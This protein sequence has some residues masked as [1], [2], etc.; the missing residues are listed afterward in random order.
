M[1]CALSTTIEA[2]TISGSHPP[3]GLLRLVKRT[4]EKRVPNTSRTYLTPGMW[5][6]KDILDKVLGKSKFVIQIRG[7]FNTYAKTFLEHPS[8]S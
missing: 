4:P 1:N 6:T 8:W 5:V 3:K 2:I 7:R